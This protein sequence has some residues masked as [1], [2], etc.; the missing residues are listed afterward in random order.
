MLVKT[1]I[2]L[3]FVLYIINDVALGAST[4][5][6][7]EKEREE[8]FNEGCGG[9]N[10]KFTKFIHTI[11]ATSI[12]EENVLAVRPR[13]CPSEKMQKRKKRHGA[14]HKVRTLKIRKIWT[15]LPPCTHLY[16]F[17]ITI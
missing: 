16:A 5:K 3:F 17:G 8:K 14:I 1:Y 2:Y 12:S 6:W 11:K 15:L 13:F 4:R 10:I 7:E 9:M